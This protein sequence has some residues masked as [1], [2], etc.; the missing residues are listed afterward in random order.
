MAVNLQIPSESEIF[1]VAGIEI[2]VTEAGIRKAN[3][4]D[5]TVFRLAEGTSVAGVFTRNR[6]CAAPVQV[7]QAHLAAGGPISALVINTGNANAGTGEEGLKKAND[8][9]AAL[10][11]LLGVP[12][13]EILPFSTGVILEPLPLDRLVAGLPGAIADLAADHWS[14]AAHG[15]MTTDTLPKISS[16][17]VQIDGKTVTFTGISKGAGMIRPNMATMLSFLATDAGIAQPLLRRLAVEIA[18]ASFNRITVDGDTSTNDSFIIAATGKSGVNVNSESDAAYAAVRQALTAAA[19]E[20]ATKIVRDAEGATKFMTIRVEEAGT[21]EEALKVAYAVAH[22]PL[23]K[24]AFF[25]SDPNL[26]R[27]LAAIGYAGIDDLDVSNIRLWLDDVLVAKNGGR[28]PDYQ[29]ADGQRVMKQAEI[30]VRIA[31]GRGDVSDTVYT[32]DFSHEYVTINADY[33][34]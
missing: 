6:F 19:L 2:G 33:R 15:I 14:S 8:T 29:E 34:S 17:K 27:I 28:N 11:K 9:C 26:G 13:T 3:R 7:C 31:L 30:S 24:T 12:A 16:A 22:S 1:P 23:V 21:T 25:A 4:R 32:C 20:L 10:G 5:L 18:D